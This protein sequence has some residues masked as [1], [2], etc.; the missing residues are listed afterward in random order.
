MASS[1]SSPDIEE[2]SSPLVLL[3]SDSSYSILC[4]LS[5][6]PKAVILNG[7]L[8]FPGTFSNVGEV[9]VVT[10]GVE[11]RNSSWQAS[12]GE[13]H[14]CCFPSVLHRAPQLHSFLPLPSAHTAMTYSSQNASSAK[15]EKLLLHCSSRATRTSHCLEIISP[16]F[17]SVFDLFLRIHSSFEIF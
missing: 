12:G 9:L 11:G 3:D 7:V 14:W 4:R 8:L 10:V 15:I 1:L 17:C 5:I 16:S 13:D 2:S 6:F